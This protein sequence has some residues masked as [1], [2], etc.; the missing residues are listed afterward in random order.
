MRY[1]NFIL[2]I[3]FLI[4]FSLLGL[5]YHSVAQTVSPGVTNASGG[6][7]TLLTTTFEW[8]IGEMALVESMIKAEMSLTNGLLQPQKLAPV[9]AD[10]FNIQANNI[11]SPNGDGENDTWRIEHIS[12]FPE[13]EVIV[14]DRGG[15]I[16]YQTKNYQNNWSGKVGEQFLAE[17]SYLYII[18]LKK[19]ELVGIKK[20]FLT[21]VR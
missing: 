12:D 2:K 4:L 1:S 14:Y 3:N 18:K 20:G 5:S 10:A 8:S 19:G 21:I 11:L 6:S 17:D 16:V 9:V 7:A 13:N 15:R